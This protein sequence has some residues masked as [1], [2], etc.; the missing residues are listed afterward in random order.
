MDISAAMTAHAIVGTTVVLFGS[1]ALALRKGSVMHRIA[2]RL[3]VVALVLMG[4][5][6]AL[7][8]GLQPASLSPLG[9]LFMLFILYLVVSAWSTISRPAA[10]ISLLDYAIPLVALGIG[11]AG[12][13]M[14]L[15]LPASAV[16]AAGAAPNEAYFFFATLAFIA[17][18]LDINHLRQGGVKGKHRIARHVWRMSCAMFFATSTLFTGP[19][20][21][22]FPQWLRGHEAL[23]VPQ[24]LVVVVAFYWLFK[25][26][27]MSCRLQTN[28]TTTH[29]KSSTRPIDL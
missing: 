18:L 6:V 19:G 20:S 13:S 14:G 21:I 16:D 15:T 10:T 11:I 23:F 24:L 1:L 17:L 9:L 29:H 28:N 26:L 7:Q 2:G 5:V 27:V 4:P 22:V 12:I 8:A 3:F 25:L